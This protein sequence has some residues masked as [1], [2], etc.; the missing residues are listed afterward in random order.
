MC[1][2]QLHER[3]V[4]RPLA[5]PPRGRTI[6]SHFQLQDILIDAED[7]QRCETLSSKN[8]LGRH[9]MPLE[10]TFIQGDVSEL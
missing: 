9:E 6:T 3:R 7:F 5:V 4:I 8:T 2:E 1:I 10:N